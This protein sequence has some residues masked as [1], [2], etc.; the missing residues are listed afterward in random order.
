MKTI[1]NKKGYAFE[2]LVA[3]IGSALLGLDLGVSMTIREDHASYLA[4]WQAA[5]GDDPAILVQA[6]S[7]AEKA[8]DYLVSFQ[9]S[10]KQAA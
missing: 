7:Q 1:L 9:L 8:I 4:S 3:E 10:S 6:A 5:I 2:E